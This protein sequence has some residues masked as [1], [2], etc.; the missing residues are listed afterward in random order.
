MQ[1]P[2]GW[3]G[4]G[5]TTLLEGAELLVLLRHQPLDAPPVLRVLRE[6]P[7]RRPLLRR[8]RLRR[9]LG[10]RRALRR[11]VRRLLLQP[12]L[13]RLER[14]HARLERRLPRG[15]G[16]ALDG[17]G[18]AHQRRLAPRQPRRARR[19]QRCPVLGPAQ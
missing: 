19:L 5:R 7:G 15:G 17:G 6:R 16:V 14:R 13:A 10:C 18:F 3:S 11:A 1:A 4:G 8:L 2:F 12:R 9:R